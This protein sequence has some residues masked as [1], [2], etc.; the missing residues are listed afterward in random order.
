MARC[1]CALSTFVMVLS[2]KLTQLDIHVAD[3][4]AVERTDDVL[5]IFNSPPRPLPDYTPNTPQSPS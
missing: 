5:R 1:K 3:T 4:I 2:A